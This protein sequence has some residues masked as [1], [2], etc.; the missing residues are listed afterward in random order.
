MI[1]LP[2]VSWASP[3][4]LT[5]Q[6]RILKTDGTPLEYNNV[7]FLFQITNPSGSCV[8]Y[9]EQITGYSM[10]NSGGV[11]DVPIGTGTVQYPLGG[12]TNVLKAFDNTATFTCGTCSLVAGTYTCADGSSTYVASVGDLRKLRVSFYDGSGWKV[13]SPDS[14]IRSVPFAGYSYSSE[15]LGTNVASDFLLKA[16]LP[17]CP[18]NS[19]LTWDGSAFTCGS[20]VGASGGTVTNVA[21]GTG[22]SGGPITSSGT[23]SLAN[24]S[25]TSGSYG[26]AN[27]VP[28]FTVDAQGRLTAAGN[29]AISLTTS[30][31]SNLSSTLSNYVLQ[32]TF[33]G[34][35]AS[36][37][38]TAS[39]SMYWN[40]VSGNFQCQSISLSW[41]SITSGKPTSL[42]GYGITDAVANA[43]GSPSVQTG[44]D[45]SKPA[46]P[47]AGAIYFSTDTNRIYQYNSGAWSLMASAAGSG[48]TITALTSDVTASGSGSV[49]ATVN[50]VGGSSAA[51][52]RAAELA[53]NA[54]TNLNTASTIVK[55]DGSGNF[56]AGAVNASSVVFRDTG[57]NTATLQAPAAIGTSYTLKLPTGQGSANQL[58]VNDGAGNLSWTSLSSMGVTG[59][60]VNTPLTNTGTAS[61]PVIGIQQATTSQSGYLSNTDWN[62]FNNKQGTSLTSA[63]IWV[64]NGSN[65]ST[66]VAP[67]G[68]VTMTNAGAFTVSKVQGTSV[69]ATAPSSAGQVLRYDGT[70]QYAPAFLRLADIRATITPFSGAFASAA[71][72]AGQSLYWQSSTDTFQCQNIAINDGQLTFTASRSANTFLAGPTSGS[73]AASFR[74]LA[75]SDLPITG[76]TGSYINGGNSFGVAASLGT[77][78][79]NSLTLETNGSPRV[80]ITN[81]GSVGIGTASPT[82]LLEVESATANSGLRVNAPSGFNSYVDFFN[83]GTK[84]GNIYWNGT[85]STFQINDIGNTNTVINGAGGFVGIGTSSPV[86]ILQIGGNNYST[87]SWTTQGSQLYIPGVI[88]TDT[89]GSGTIANR[90]ITSIGTSTLAASNA[91]TITTAS[92]MYIASPPSAGTNVTITNPLALQIANGNSSFGGR[93]GIGTLSPTHN[94]HV[95]GSVNVESNTA[96]EIRMRNTNLTST[97]KSWRIVQDAAAN[98]TRIANDADNINYMAF[99]MDT[100]NVGIG[101]VNPASKLQVAGNLH[102]GVQSGAT[103]DNSDYII[104]SNGQL[105]LQSNQSGLA[106]NQYVHLVLDAGTATSSASNIVMK[107]NAT[108]RM[109]VTNTGISMG[110]T[111]Q[112]IA[113]KTPTLVV[114]ANGTPTI[115]SYTTTASA[116]N[117]IIFA[118]PNGEVG[119]VNT[120]GNTTIFGTASDRR[121]KQN[122]RDFDVAYVDDVISRLRPRQWEWKTDEKHGEGF[123]AQ[124]LA[125]V[126]PE[127]VSKGDDNPQGQRG[128]E[129]FKLWT[130]DYSKIT[131]YLTAEIQILRQKITDIFATQSREIA[132]VKKENAELKQ[133]VYLLKQYICEKDPQANVCKK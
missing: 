24:T 37:N 47:T 21:T 69:S 85:S 65:V 49:A 14:I 11:F 66:A 63:N 127:A 90:A 113:G 106:D 77:N 79:G 43:G 87:T 31:I 132:S 26:S 74:T 118:N 88:I 93:V 122:I 34:Y 53:A 57:S 15:R 60:S 123:I 103:D 59:L 101:T 33:N 96:Q 50:S 71:C 9:Q 8:I 54:A 129:G 86:S 39:Q 91:E 80:T 12:A 56:S 133:E 4:S 82:A 3:A 119:Y 95:V 19:F 1:F 20:V 97:N 27:Q 130:V 2:L 32:S 13:V 84:K 111:A 108:E 120:D 62:T 117:H 67:S 128:E 99:Q 55:R 10:V 29:V 6:G 25:V 109:R 23:I 36:A 35:V 83:N 115:T 18:A 42:S 64:G 76:S 114:A 38:C 81:T 30:D 5:Y 48:G 124:E 102:L 107:T 98:F 7:S 22:L 89:T 78:D 112:S 41:A 51:N 116:I 70:A 105:V 61:S 72:S 92:T 100:G 17:T 104:K 44:L 58:L 125:E 126:I 28:A 121:L 73:G 45:A 75:S 94:L 16:G 110:T 40:S 68:D 46:S 131:P 52:I